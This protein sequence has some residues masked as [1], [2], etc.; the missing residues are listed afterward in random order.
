MFK[1]NNKVDINKHEIDID[2]LFKQNV[3][4]LSAIKELYRKLK[5]VEEK[6][7]HIKYIDSTLANKLKKEYEKLKKIILDENVQAKLANDIETINLQMDTKANFCNSVSDLKNLNAKLGQMIT[8]LGFYSD[9]DGGGSTYKIVNDDVVS[10]EATYIQLKNGLKAKMIISDNQINFLQ[11]GA[12]PNDNTFDC[13]PI[14]DKYINACN[15]DN[16]TY[17]LKIPYGDWYFS[18][19]HIYRYDG[20]NIQG[21]PVFPGRSTSGVMIR[22][23]HDNQDYIWKIGGDSDVTLD[24]PYSSGNLMNKIVTNGFTFTTVNNGNLYTTKYGMFYL[25]CSMYVNFDQLYF[26]MYRGTGMVMRSSWEIN[27]G[28]LNFRNQRNS[29]DEFGV[30]PNLLFANVRTIKGIAANVSALEIQSLMFEGVSGDYILSEPKSGFS[31]NS[32]INLNIENG[33]DYDSR[34][35]DATSKSFVAN[36][37]VSSY[38]PLGVI[39]GFYRFFTI[40]NINIVDNNAKSITVNGKTYYMAGVLFDSC[41]ISLDDYDRRHN[42][43]V[44]NFS[45][46]SA[47][48]NNRLAIIYSRY[49]YYRNQVSIGSLMIQDEPPVYIVDAFAGGTYTIGAINSYYSKL[50]PTIN[51]YN[52]AYEFAR[53]GSRFGT[54]TSDLEAYNPLNLVWRRA[55]NDGS[56]A[57]LIPYPFR[58]GTEHNITFIVKADVGVSYAISIT[59]YQNGAKKAKTINGSGTGKYEEISTTVNS[60]YGSNLEVAHSAGTISISKFA[61]I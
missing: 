47:N 13:K 49:S 28:I 42:I 12:K 19:T 18:A 36:E 24:T 61:I 46:R 14:M 40:N 16:T 51:N 8:T 7:S 38:V 26:Y 25:D 37:D 52:N 35:T 15:R 56:F 41:D 50:K 53:N 44:G 3:N 55:Q 17:K 57:L 54:V 31:H 33:F 21:E 29:N 23:F 32:I 45:Y 10:D 60:D 39:R 30:K 48:A 1:E 27:V 2:T 34:Y 22:P 11:L 6:I 20:V 4:D 58:Y 59:Q 9:G 43:S 5:E